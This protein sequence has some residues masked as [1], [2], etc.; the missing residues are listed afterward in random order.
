MLGGFNIWT[1]FETIGAHGCGRC[2]RWDRLYSVVAHSLGRIIRVTWQM[3]AFVAGSCRSVRDRYTVATNLG[4]VC[5][6]RPPK[7]RLLPGILCGA[8]SRGVFRLGRHF[9]MGKY[10]SLIVYY[11]PSFAFQAISV[12]TKRACSVLRRRGCHVPMH[13]IPRVGVYCPGFYVPL[14]DTTGAICHTHVDVV[15]AQC[16]EWVTFEHTVA[17]RTIDHPPLLTWHVYV[18]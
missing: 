15:R 7:H 3:D 6:C 13:P 1:S 14:W 11:R 18:T 10:P 2:R 5:R 4:S 8:T 12:M 16:D 17:T 9:F